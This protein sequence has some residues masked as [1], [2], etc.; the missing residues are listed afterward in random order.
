VINLE[1]DVAEM[2]AGLAQAMPYVEHCVW[3]STP[4]RDEADR[5]IEATPTERSAI[6]RRY[7]AEAKARLRAALSAPRPLTRAIRPDQL[8]PALRLHIR[9]ALRVGVSAREMARRLNV[10]R[11]TILRA[12]REPLKRGRPRTAV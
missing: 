1:E 6:R 9:S 2:F 3:H 5:F 4:P 12:L 7:A 11:A 10:S 8:T